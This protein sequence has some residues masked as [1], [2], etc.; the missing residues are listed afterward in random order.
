MSHAAYRLGF[1]FYGDGPA[2][3]IDDARWALAALDPADH[4]LSGVFAASDGADVPYRL[5]AAKAPR[6]LVLLL[7]GATDYSGAFDEIGPRFAALGITALAID[8]RGFGATASRGEWHG[9]NRMIRD[10]IEAVHY[11]RSRFGGE[12]P[13]F[14]A[15]ESMGA[16]L[17]VHVAA[18]APDLD[19][20]GLV[21]AAPGA[22]S[23]NLRR[24][25]GSTFTRVLRFL[26]PRSSIVIERLSAW[27]FTPAA[28]IRL[29][30]DPLVLRRVRPPMLFGLFKL[31]RSAV[32]EA[33]HVH[34]PAL[35][36]VG[37]REDLLR[38]ACIRRLHDGLAGVKMW[39]RFRD[40]PHLLLH[41]KENERVLKTV[42][43][44]IE[45]RL[46]RRGV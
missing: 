29:M 18:R 1:E 37:G 32:D 13:V 38:V 6:A 12:L 16:A 26:L 17:A 45:A 3:G 44:W 24:L 10:A 43:D 27:E 20:A 36:M 39:Q 25:F 11:L 5:W 40:G 4:V 19:L 22:I 30:G 42:F 33:E 7:H 2:P 8:Q 41:W 35:T 14:V 15:G 21:L 34:V 28:A 9:K 46:A 23:G 31:S